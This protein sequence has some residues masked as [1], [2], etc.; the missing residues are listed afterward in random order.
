MRPH[1]TYN[2]RMLAKGEAAPYFIW[3][4][5]D[6]FKKQP[7]LVDAVPQPAK[8][9]AIAGSG[10]LG[11]ARGSFANARGAKIGIFGAEPLRLQPFELRFIAQRRAPDRWV[12]DMSKDDGKLLRPVDYHAIPHEEDRLFIPSE[13]VSLFELKG[14]VKS[15]A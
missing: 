3:P 10:R 4:N 6:P 13:Y 15:A 8:M 7:S 14:W 5:L 12:I 1:K 9:T 2:E 11:D